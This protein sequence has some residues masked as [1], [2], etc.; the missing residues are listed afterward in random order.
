MGKVKEWVS[1]ATNLGVIAGLVLVA[2]QIQQTNSA[3]Q[4]ETKKWNTDYRNA[5]RELFTDLYFEIV[6]DENLSS[7]WRRGSAGTELSE[8]EAFRFEMLATQQFWLTLDSY[9][10]NKEWD[11]EGTDAL[12]RFIVKREQSPG[13]RAVSERLLDEHSLDEYRAE[14]NRVRQELRVDQRVL[15]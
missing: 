5:R 15:E 12:L 7:I 1:V 10:N 14:L 4:L 8:E 11:P 3:L 2:Y 9:R 13:L 6:A